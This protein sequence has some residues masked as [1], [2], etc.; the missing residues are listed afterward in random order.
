MP[1]MTTP[2]DDEGRLDRVATIPNAISLIRLAC[3]PVFLWLLFGRENRTGAAFLLGGLGATDWVDGYIARHFNQVSNLGKI[4]DP[5]ADKVLLVVGM[6]AILIDGSVPAI[7][8]WPAIA[9]E[10]LVAA[11]TVALGA[12]GA[13]RIDVSWAGKCGTLLMMTAFPLFL[14]GHG[15]GPAYAAAWAFAIPGL[16]MA[17][18]AAIT[19]VKPAME[20]LREGRAGRLAT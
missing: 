16:L 15:S 19:Y 9:R 1:P 12:L 7:V 17:W 6:V 4:L 20:A 14:W 8:F 10:V 11:T 3:V 5:I 18:Y 2:Q 13:R